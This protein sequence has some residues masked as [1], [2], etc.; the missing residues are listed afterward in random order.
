MSK[1][2]LIER[3]YTVNNDGLHHIIYIKIYDFCDLIHDDG[4]ADT[5]CN[6]VDD[7]SL[8]W[9]ELE[10]D[11]NGDLSKLLR[12]IEETYHAVRFH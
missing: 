12:E 6:P 1:L 10:R 11:Y 7:F 2:Q 9:S 8:T 5:V 4:F 3:R